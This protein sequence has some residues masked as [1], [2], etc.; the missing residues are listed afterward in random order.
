[1]ELGKQDNELK[2]VRTRGIEVHNM[3]VQGVNMSVWDMAGQEEYHTFHDWMIPNR[4]ATGNCCVYVILCDP[5]CKANR[6]RTRGISEIKHELLYW[7]QFVAS[8]TRRS[9]AYRPHVT[10]VLTH[11]DL[12]SKKKFLK[13]LL[14]EA[15][16]EFHTQFEDLLEI[17][18]HDNSFF[19]DARS[20]YH[21]S[22]VLSSIYTASRSILETLPKEIKVCKVLLSIIQERNKSGVDIPFLKWIEFSLM[23]ED[24]DGLKSSDYTDETILT[25]KRE[26]VATSLHDGGFIIYF[27]GIDIV[28]LNPQWFCRDIMGEMISTCA[29]LD[30]HMEMIKDGVISKKHLQRVFTKS[31]AWLTLDEHFDAFLHMMMKLQVCYEQQNEYIMIP[32][33][34]QDTEELNWQYVFDDEENETYNYVGTRLTSQD[35]TLTILTSGFFPR[36]QV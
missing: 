29:T 16:D 30:P 18:T 21:G 6:N 13:D 36:L 15:I 27:K 26:F 24:V 14:N 8:N 3:N 34:L 2:N 9:S 5:T 11:M 7:L 17:D 19:I 25:K 4:S 12:W 1:M 28:I 10:I 31:F 23:C 33:T 35:E 32:S 22:M 20:Q